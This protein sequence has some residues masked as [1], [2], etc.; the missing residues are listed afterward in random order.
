MCVCVCVHV[1]DRDRA[2]NGKMEIKRMCVTGR[3]HGCVCVCVCVH[4]QVCEC[5][6]KFGCVCG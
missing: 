5:V 6:C 1:C 4:V 3:D 2:L